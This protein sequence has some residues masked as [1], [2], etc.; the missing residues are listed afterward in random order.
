MK[1]CATLPCYVVLYSVTIQI[2]SFFLQIF[3]NEFAFFLPLLA[4]L[5]TIEFIHKVPQTR[6]LALVLIKSQNENNRQKN[7][8]DQTGFFT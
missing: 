3:E 8:R 5:D 4:I 7:K 2:V 6:I 1:L